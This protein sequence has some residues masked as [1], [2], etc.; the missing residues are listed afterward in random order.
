MCNE[1]TTPTPTQIG[2]FCV[3]YIVSSLEWIGVDKYVIFRY[4]LQIYW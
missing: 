3:V 2:L 4:L 1:P